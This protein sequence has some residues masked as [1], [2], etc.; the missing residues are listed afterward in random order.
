MRLSIFAFTVSLA[1]GGVGNVQVRG[2]TATQSVLSYTAPDNNACQIELSE[3]Q[4]YAPL[5]HDVDPVLFAGSNLDNRPESL[6]SGMQRV[7]VAGKRRADKAL[8]GHWYSRALQAFTTHYFRITCGSSQAK[9][10]FLTA[11]IGL[12]STYLDPLAP[13]PAVSS[14]P[15][16]SVTGSYGWPE[17]IN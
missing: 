17:F 7:F 4:T 9:G 11:N 13:D 6:P 12:G 15:Y 14:R 1:Y 16:Y 2:V 10:Q 3:S 5:A 8:D